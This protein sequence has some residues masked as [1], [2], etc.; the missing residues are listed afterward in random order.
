MTTGKRL[1]VT[2]AGGFIGHHLVHRLRSDGHWVRGVD[3]KYPKYEASFAEEFEI[4]D[5]LKADNCLL[6][7]AE[8]TTLTTLLPTW[9]GSATSPHSKLASASAG[10]TS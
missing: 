7:V 8:F 2:G 9:V 10:T 4:L 5:L 3:L 1:L 6:P